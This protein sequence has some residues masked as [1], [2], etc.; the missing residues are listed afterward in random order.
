MITERVSTADGREAVPVKPAGAVPV[1]PAPDEPAPEQAALPKAALHTVTQSAGGSVILRRRSALQTRRSVLY[2]HCDQET[3]VPEDLV[4]WYTERGFHFYVA[5]LR[6]QDRA[7]RPR[8]QRGPD[9]GECFDR[10]DS[11]CRHLRDS[12]GIDMIIVAA[13]AADAL[14]AALWCDAR[15]DAGLAD[16]LILSSPVFGRRLRRGLDI[17]CPVLLMLPAAS[18]GS[19]GGPAGRLAARKRRSKETAATVRLGPHVTW[20]TLDEGLDGQAPGASPDQRRFFDEL[21]RWLGAYMY[22]KVRDQLL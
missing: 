19:P 17:A 20:L 13:H 5:D 11:A 1:K 15:R 6:P 9:R 8:R 14:T 12:E 21:G 7:D 22:G 16:A 4:A 10:L 3:F 2:L 18:P